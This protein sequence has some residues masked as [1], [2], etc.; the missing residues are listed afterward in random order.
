MNIK[1]GIKIELHSWDYCEKKYKS[2]IEFYQIP[3]NDVMTCFDMPYLFSFYVLK[4]YS[5]EIAEQLFLY[6]TEKK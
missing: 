6:L 3:Y 2:Y 4:K 5:K 1:K